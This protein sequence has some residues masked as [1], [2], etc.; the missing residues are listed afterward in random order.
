M[1]KGRRGGI[2]RWKRATFARHPSRIHRIHCAEFIFLG[3]L[4]AVVGNFLMA[5]CV[6]SGLV[7]GVR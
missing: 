5:D 6:V 3:D 1:H 4:R 2:A 7:A